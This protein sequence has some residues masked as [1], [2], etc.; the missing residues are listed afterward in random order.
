MRPADVQVDHTI[1]FE[2]DT[3]PDDQDIICA[4]RFACG[5]TGTYSAAYGPTTP[6]DDTAVLRRLARATHR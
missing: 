1:R 2:G 3:N 6:P 5:C 4:I